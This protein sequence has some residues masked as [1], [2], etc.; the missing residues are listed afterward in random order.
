MV[1]ALASGRSGLGSNPGC[2]HCI[3]FLSK[4]HYSH[5][6]SLHPGTSELNAGRSLAM[7]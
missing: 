2:G 5:S 4:T 1:N 3:V 6:A 7:D